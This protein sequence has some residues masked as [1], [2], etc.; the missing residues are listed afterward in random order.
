MLSANTGQIT[1]V[2]GHVGYRVLLEVI[3][4]GYHV[5]EVVRKAEQENQ[6]RNTESVKPFTKNLEFVVVDDL[7]KDAAFDGVLD[8]IDAVA[9]VASPLPLTVS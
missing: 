2:S 3:L 5:R 6:I 8:G 1:G 9:H 7:L 4:Q